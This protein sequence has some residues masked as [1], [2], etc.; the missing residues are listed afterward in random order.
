MDTQGPAEP[1]AAAHR[2][3]YWLRSFVA[4]GITAVICTYPLDMVRARL[5]FQVKGEHKYTGIIHAFKTIYTKEGGFIGFYRGL[6]PTVVGMAPYAVSS[7]HVANYNKLTPRP[8][9]GFSFFTFSTLKS[10]G[11]AQAPNLLGRPSLDNPEVLVLKTHVSLLYGGMAGAIAQTISYPLDVTRRRMQ[12][13]AALPDADKCLFQKRAVDFCD[14]TL[15]KGLNNRYC[16][17]RVNIIQKNEDGP[18]KHLTITASQSLEDTELCILKNDWYSVPVVP[19]DIIHLEG[20]CHSGTWIINRDSGYLILY[21]DLLLSGTTV[22]NSIRCMRKAVLSEKFRSCESSSRQ[23]L[24]GTILHETFQQGVTNNFAHEKLQELAFRTVHGPKYL[25]E[26]YYLNLKQEEIMQ[27]IEEYLPSISKWAEDFMHKPSQANHNK[28]QLKLPSEGKIEDLSCNIEVT[29]FLDIEENIWSPRFGLK[30]KIDVTVGVKIHRKSGTQYKIMPLELKTGKESNSIEHRSQVVLYTLL[31]QER[32]VDPEAGFL[33]YLKTGNMYP[34]SG[35]R[36]DRRE[37]LKL[38]NQLAFYLFHSMCKSA[39]GNKQTQLASLPPLI[40]DSRACKYCSQMHNCFL[41]SRAVEQQMDNV[42]IPPAVVPIIEKETQHLKLSHLQYFSLWYLMLTLESQCGEGKKGR[43]NIWLMPASEREK[44]GDCIGNMIRVEHVQEASEGQYLHYFQRKNGTMPGTNLL[45]GDR[46]VVSGEKTL[47]GLSAG[48]VKEV[49]VTTVSCLL[50]RNLSKLP[51]DTI[52]RLDHEEGISG[53]DA[54]LRNLSKLMENSSASEKLRNLIID[55]HKPLFIQHLSSVL[56]PEAKETVA[57]I[58]KGLNKPQKQAMKQV[59]LSKDYTLIV[60]MPGTGK[61][62]TICALVRILYACGFSVLLTSFTHTA[63]DNILLKL[64]RFK[65]GFL[66]LGRAQ[67]VHPDIRKFTEEEI[68]RSKSIKSITHLEELYNNQPVVATTCMGVNHPIFARKLF[69]FCIVDEASQISQPICLGPLF[70]SHRFVLVGDHQQ[71][72]PL[73]HNTEARDLGMSESLFKR[74][75]QNKNAV[76]QLTVQYRMNS[77]I[78]S[79]SNKLVYEG[80]LECGSEKVSK[81]TVILPNLKNLTLELELFADSSETWLKETLEPNNPVC[82]LNTEKVPAP[83]QA[84]K[85]GVSNMTEAKL[86]LFLTSFFIKA[87]CKAS[88]IGIVSPYRHQLKII[89]DLMKSSCISTVEVNT[90]DKYQGRDKSIIIVSFVRNNNDGNLGTL[91]MDWRRLN[92]AITRA[93]HKLIM[94]GCVPSLCRYPPLEKLLCHLNSEAMIFNLPSGA[95]ER[96][97]QVY[98]LL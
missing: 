18:E 3:F 14:T 63:V 36:M 94:L 49:N 27:E 41:Y 32:R 60:G 78:M 77:K 23:M 73:V 51:K 22:S 56:P 2:D 28:M 16:V 80:K 96:V 42:L 69:D 7:Q 30:G 66:R 55:F 61:T 26:M 62:T 83:E 64:A 24:I 15:S 86:V 29:E 38:R 52:F 98:D 92:V 19:G 1:N 87:G 48:Y 35:N 76:V 74:L 84:E 13:G 43:K 58:L 89:T 71:L 25:K 10:I 47:L 17:L 8:H 59:L 12:L 11:L 5:A 50:D 40:D 4:G 45:V 53:I 37:L 39:L 82:F 97:Y 33:L 85:G 68:C 44:A 57:N 20:D 81:A 88:D 72:P 9:L 79:L 90:V 21:P 93:K 75:E 54:P 67:K 95:H 91:L 46:V 65:V 34:V 70:Y 31:N 6:M